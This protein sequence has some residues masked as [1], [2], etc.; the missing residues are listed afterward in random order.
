[1][2]RIL[3]LFLLFLF[4]VGCAPSNGDTAQILFIGNSYTYVNN[5]PK[6]F[7]SLSKSGGHRVEVGM[8]AE[9]GWTLEDHVESAKTMRAIESS[10]WD[11]V[12]VQEQSQIPASAIFRER[13]MYPAA[14]TLVAKI[15]GV[16]AAPVLFLTPAHLD[17]WPEE[18]L[19]Y[20]AMQF[21]INAGYWSLAQELNVLVAPAGIAWQNAHEQYPEL[22]L[23]Q[24]DG[25]HPDK[26]GTYL[27]ACVF[28]ATIFRES[29]VGLS[30]RGGLS[31]GTAELLQTIASQT[32]L[33]TP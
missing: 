21:Q 22:A 32:V 33:N 8:E 27:T 26:Q 11:F 18:R 23:W 2:K 20:A 5:L 29:P 31:K 10:E 28:Y 6:M 14:R 17:G 7:A 12:V 19:D 9:G 24:S 15:R 16:G 13:R 3:L 30:Y 25:S 4:C 1:M